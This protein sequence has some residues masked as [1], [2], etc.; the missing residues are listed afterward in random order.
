MIGAHGG[1]RLHRPGNHLGQR[2]AGQIVDPV[3]ERQQAHLRDV[4]EQELS[5]AGQR[6]PLV[7]AQVGNAVP[8]A[9]LGPLGGAAGAE[10]ADRC[11]AAE[12]G[13]LE[14]DH[15]NR[16]NGVPRG[17]GLGGSTAAAAVL[18][19]RGAVLE[20][21]REY[22]QGERLE[23]VRPGVIDE[24]QDA[25]V[26]RRH[27]RDGS[28][29]QKVGKR[30][31]SLPRSVVTL[32]LNAEAAEADGLSRSRLT[33]STRSHAIQRIALVDPPPPHPLRLRASA[34]KGRGR[35]PTV[36]KLTQYR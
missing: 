24:C 31:V 20:L 10:D 28:T 9:V 27:E 21:V 17:D 7:E 19:V 26:Q 12:L 33:T 13:V 8:R 15:R 25:I 29:R 23:T 16:G 22:R 32:F 11:T 36:V 3:D 2:G 6:R 30:V 14:G 35:Q 18:A 4:G 34:L 1:E 5:Q